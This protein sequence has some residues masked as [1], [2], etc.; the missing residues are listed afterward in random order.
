MFCIPSIV[1]LILFVHGQNTIYS[2]SSIHV[3]AN[4]GYF[5]NGKSFT[6]SKWTEI[7]AKYIREVND[8]GSCSVRKLA[9]I[10]MISRTSAQKA[11]DSYEN[12]SEI[13]RKPRG[14]K[15]R[16]VGSLKKFEMK[17]HEYI[18]R[19]YRKN[20]SL[21]ADGYIDKFYKKFGIEISRTFVSSWFHTGPFKGTMRET[22]TFPPNRDSP[23]VQ[24]LVDEYIDSSSEEDDDEDEVIT[25][26]T[27]KNKKE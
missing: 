12:R 8:N 19:L 15:R 25:T 17:H 24:E 21:P 27:K 14:T 4:G 7:I 20:P 2:M 23:R 5:E 10:A 26:T 13:V 22:S 16:G 9:R 6:Q 1:S 18:Y 3:N 11:I